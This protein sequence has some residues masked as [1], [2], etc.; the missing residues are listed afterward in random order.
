MGKSV[1]VTVKG[2]TARIYRSDS[3]GYVSWLVRYFVHG[4][5]KSLRATTL[6]EARQKAK[7]AL[8]EVSSGAAHVETFTPRE[9]A[10]VAAAVAKLREVGVPLIDA[11]SDF[12]AARKALPAKWTVA[13]A[14]RGFA[15]Q[16]ARKEKESAGPPPTKFRDAVA[17]FLDR[18][19]RRGLSAAYK[20][21]C[22][23]HLT[24]IGRTLNDAIIQTIRQPELTA[25]LESSTKGGARRFNNLR[26]TLNALFGFCQKEGILPRDRTHEAAL[27][28]QKDMGRHD[29]IA[30]YT[31]AEM[32]II[33]ANID[34]GLV[35]WAVLGGLAGLR[36]SE[37]HR[38]R[39]ENIRLDA[40]V[41][42]LDK[43]L[44]KTK[45]RRVI[46]MCE[47]LRA[48]IELIP[49]A[50]RKTGRLYDMPFKTYED[51]LHRA[52][53]KMVDGKGKLLVEKRPNALRHSYGTYRFSILQDEF[54]VS[55]EMGNSP[56]QLRE[57]YAELCLP[58]DA[59]AWFAIAPKSIP[60]AKGRLTRHRG[61]EKGQKRNRR[62]RQRI[63]PD[64]RRD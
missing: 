64:F 61:S 56:G 40:G 34:A 21:D 51:H 17:K 10:T 59:E 20:S 45:R 47:S 53:M 3:G 31:P 58:R 37:I 22:R 4:K 36:V 13:D 44:T 14:A 23:K 15:A 27:I 2:V 12:V 16:M 9:A 60:G 8:E 46:P 5:A 26:S 24:L 7:D 19:E 50:K 57:H 35:P 41:I 1:T 28:E 48:W 63:S 39:W 29:S 49:E 55:A 11:V 43:A 30:I 18:N 33:L 32:R 62:A 25:C 54:R 38:L 6:E 52:W 42:T